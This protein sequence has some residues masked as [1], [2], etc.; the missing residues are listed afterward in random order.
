MYTLGTPPKT[1][2]KKSATSEF[3]ICYLKVTSTTKQ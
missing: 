3:N 2:D 1:S